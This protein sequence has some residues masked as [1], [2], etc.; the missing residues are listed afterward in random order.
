MD[1][2]TGANLGFEKEIFAAADKLRGNMEY[3]Q[4]FL[5]PKLSKNPKQVVIQMFS[6][7]SAKTRLLLQDNTLIMENLSNVDITGIRLDHAKDL[8]DFAF[9]I[10][11]TIAIN[12]DES[13]WVWPQ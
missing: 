4:R 12:Q 7:D 1:N 8:K 3:W 11:D 5:M 9:Y 2:V 6:K 13:K 10:K